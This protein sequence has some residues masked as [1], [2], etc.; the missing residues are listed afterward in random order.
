M[1]CSISLT[2]KVNKMNDVVSGD[3]AVQHAQFARMLYLVHGLSFVFTL[4]TLSFILLIINYVKR[5]D[6]A[7]TFVYSHHNWMINTF[8]IYF[9]LCC[10]AW[11]LVFTIIGLPLALILFGFN[12]LYTAYRLIK[13]FMELN[14]SRPVGD[15]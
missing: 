4:G 7:G 13:G 11:V 10:L 9:G 3:N 6:T 1:A 2:K 15:A 8:W 14:V 12:W 5:P